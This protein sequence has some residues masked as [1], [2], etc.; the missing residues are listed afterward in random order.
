MKT[1]T[2]FIFLMLISIVT[3]A[4]EKD[5]LIYKMYHSKKNVKEVTYVKSYYANGKM[6]SEGWIVLEQS[7]AESEILKVKNWRRY[8]IVDHKFGIWK[9]YHK[10]GSL[11]GIDSNGVN[12][13]EISKQYDYD[14]NGCLTKVSLMKPAVSFDKKSQGWTSSTLDA[15]EWIN[16][17][18]YNC[19][20]IMK[21][22]YFEKNYKKTGVWKWYENGAL[23]KTKEYKDNKLIE[24]KKFN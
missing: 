6:E 9:R 18:Y 11:A 17:R 13:S 16:Y 23:I 5:S 10:D 12:V 21:E 20:G 8:D 4:Q 22:E 7:S 24:E 19:N 3:H 14:K 2:A 15:V 1:I